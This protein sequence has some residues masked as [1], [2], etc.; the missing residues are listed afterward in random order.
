LSSKLLPTEIAEELLTK[1]VP[2]VYIEIADRPDDGFQATV[3]DLREALKP[4]GLDV[5]TVEAVDWGTSYPHAAQD[6]TRICELQQEVDDLAVL[7]LPQ[8]KAAE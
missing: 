7:V 1:P 6:A 3:G 2:G 8:K 5:T 4:L